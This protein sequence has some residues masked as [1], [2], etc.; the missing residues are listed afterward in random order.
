MPPL[1]AAGERGLL[2]ALRDARQAEAAALG[3]ASTHAQPLLPAST[4]PL[5]KRLIAW[6]GD[7]ADAA[8]DTSAE[9]GRYLEASMDGQEPAGY[10]QTSDRGQERD[11][12]ASW[13]AQS[14]GGAAGDASGFWAQVRAASRSDS[15]QTA[16]AVLLLFLSLTERRLCWACR[17][18]K[19]RLGWTEARTTSRMAMGMR[20]GSGRDGQRR[21]GA[22][23]GAVRRDR[24]DG[25]RIWSEVMAIST[26][27]SPIAAHCSVTVSVRSSHLCGRTS[28]PRRPKS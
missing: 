26:D 25:N 7:A 13:H 11:E 9:L 16:M 10:Q 27:R 15:D 20:R 5:T 19:M 14:G 17:A 24:S 23:G 2:S 22:A 6:P 18:R 3:R 8:A 28:N 12:F 1:Q 21:R 4:W